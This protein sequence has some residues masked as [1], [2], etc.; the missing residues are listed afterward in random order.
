VEGHCTG[1]TPRILGIFKSTTQARTF[2]FAPPRNIILCN[3]LLG[4]ERAEGQC[5]SS[6]LGICHGACEGKEGTRLYNNDSKKF[7]AA[8]RPGAPGPYTGPI[9]CS[10]E[11]IDRGDIG[12]GIHLFTRQLVPFSV[13]RRVDAGPASNFRWAERGS[14]NLTTRRYKILCGAYVRD[15]VNKKNIPGALRTSEFQGNFFSLSRG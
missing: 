1:R 11:R 3:K 12:T 2:L 8:R 7:I 10:E 6:Q 5:F 9:S 15:P 14:R 4:L 13:M